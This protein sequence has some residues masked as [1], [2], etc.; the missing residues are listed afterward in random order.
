M[1]RHFLA[2]VFPADV[3]RQ[4]WGGGEKS[5]NAVGETLNINI[6]N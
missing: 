1:T 2:N 4:P 3:G 6:K 5:T